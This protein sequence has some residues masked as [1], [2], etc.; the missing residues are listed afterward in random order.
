[1]FCVTVSY[2]RGL[3]PNRLESLSLFCFLLLIA[4]GFK[5]LLFSPPSPPSPLSCR[6]PLHP[7]ATTWFRHLGRLMA[8]CT[9]NPVT[10]RQ[11]GVRAASSL[12]HGGTLSSRHVT[13][14]Y[15]VPHLDK[16]LDISFRASFFLVA[17]FRSVQ[18][19]PL[20]VMQSN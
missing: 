20:T 17:Y 4:Q 3:N 8:T 13:P 14:A 6:I 18:L 10:K 19:R 15:Q 16:P 12:L 11:R 5:P 1:M 7:T 9:N 2:L